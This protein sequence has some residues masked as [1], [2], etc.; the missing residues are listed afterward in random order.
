MSFYYRGS[1][2][3][4]RGRGHIPHGLWKHG[5]NKNIRFS[6]HFNADSEEFHQFSTIGH[7]YIGP[8]IPPCQASLSHVLHQSPL[9]PHPNI[10][11]FPQNAND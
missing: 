6:L 8:P 10:H 4:S 5:R 3:Q 9:Q 7:L 11:E 1:S 2:R